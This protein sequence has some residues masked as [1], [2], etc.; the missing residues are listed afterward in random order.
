[1]NFLFQKS[2]VI[3]WLIWLFLEWL[4]SEACW[5]SQAFSISL[6]AVAQY[7]LFLLRMIQ[8]KWKWETYNQWP[9]VSML[10]WTIQPPS[11]ISGHQVNAQ[12]LHGSAAG[13]L[14]LEVLIL[15]QEADEHFVEDNP[16]IDNS[17]LLYLHATTT[18]SQHQNF[19]RNLI[20]EIENEQQHFRMK[21]NKK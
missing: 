5:W 17:Q 14:D 20:F 6:D 10:R 2:I 9:Q 1:M 18:N 21:M 8:M 13:H 19:R 12:A 7:I 15:V 16:D 11:T 3:K 4:Q